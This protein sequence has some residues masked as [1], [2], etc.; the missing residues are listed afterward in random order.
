MI[1]SLT[2][3]VATEYVIGV[4]SP[5]WTPEL[6]QELAALLSRH[7]GGANAGD[8]ARRSTRRPCCPGM[9][10]GTVVVDFRQLPADTVVA[11]AASTAR[12]EL[13]RVGPPS[14]MVVWVIPVKVLVEPAQGSR[15]IIDLAN[16]GVILTDAGQP[17]AQ[18]AVLAGT[19]GGFDALVYLLKSLGFA[20]YSIAE[21][22]PLPVVEARTPSGRVV[23]GMTGKPVA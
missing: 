2:Q 6:P 7:C 20:V 19:G 18:V 11:G 17:A 5:V 1:A 9:R 16:V 3:G 21:G 13:N 8:G 23:R 14:Q 12:A 10:E 4:P 22:A 15:F